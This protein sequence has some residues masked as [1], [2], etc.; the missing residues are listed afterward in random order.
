M[1]DAV[2]GEAVS[3]RPPGSPFMPRVRAALLDRQRRSGAARPGG[4]R[5]RHGERRLPDA[6]VKVFVTASAEERAKRRHKQLNGKGID[7]NIPE[8]FCAISASATRATRAAA[9]PLAGGRRRDPGYDRPDDR[10]GRALRPVAAVAKLRPAGFARIAKERQAHAVRAFERCASRGDSPSS[11]PPRETGFSLAAAGNQER[12][13][14][15][16]TQ[17]AA[18]PASATRG[19]LRRA[20]RGIA[21][22]PGDAPRRAD[23]RRS[24]R[25]STT[26]SSSSTP[27]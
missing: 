6:A 2:R 4:R 5:A 22:P 3:A 13:T 21:R 8:S 12:S 11:P 14:Q 9:P 17:T 27:A 19:K 26:T 18:Q 7:V 25:A 16:L 10:R 23:H 20:V 24:H 15:W 1:T